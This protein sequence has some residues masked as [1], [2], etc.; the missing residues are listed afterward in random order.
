VS[1]DSKGV[2]YKKICQESSDKELMSSNSKDV[3][4]KK[5][6]QESSDKG[7]ISSDSKDVAYELTL[8]TP[9]CENLLF[10]KQLYKGR[11]IVKLLSLKYKNTRN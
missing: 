6:C 2:A 9:R 5:I 4:R 8:I 3:A 1:S 11:T 10:N 7:L